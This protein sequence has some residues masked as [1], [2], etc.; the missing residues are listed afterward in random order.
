ILLSGLG[1][2]GISDLYR[3]HLPEGRLE[4]LT[5]DH[6][7]DLD[8]S[9]SP[10]GSRVAFASDRTAGGDTGA[11]NLFVLELATGSIRQ[12]TAGAWL[13]ESPV[14]GKDG[15]IWF[16]SSRDGVLNA[17]SVDTLGRGRRETAAWTGRLDV[18]PVP[19]REAVTASGFDLFTLNAW[20]LPLD[21][22]ARRDTFA[23]A[24]AAPHGTWTLPGL[25][26]SP[27]EPLAGEP[28]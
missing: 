2:D 25:V 4:R 19:G 26:G 5:N 12:L 10:D 22:V 18:H 1:E 23:L 3:V 16:T 14:W 9:P 27:V 20:L 11:M 21:T 8:P 15:R 17:F 6:Y 24:E 28:Y 7:Q 13:D